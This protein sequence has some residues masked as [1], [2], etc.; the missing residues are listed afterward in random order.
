M[1][2]LRVAFSIVTRNRPAVLEHTLRQIALLHPPPDDIWVCVDGCSEGTATM[3]RERFPETHVLVE[4]LPRGSVHGRNR[5]LRESN[6][7]VVLSL[8]DDSHPIQTDFV[9][10]LRELHRLHPKVAVFAFPQVTDEFPETLQGSPLQKSECPRWIATYLDSGASYW[11]AAYLELPGFVS[12]FVHAYEEPDYALQCLG[13][14]WEVRLEP[15]LSVRHHYTAVH[16]NTLHTHLSHCRNE[17]WSILLRAPWPLVPFM[18][19]FR[20]ARQLANAGRRGGWGWLRRHPGNWWE[21]WKGA[22][23][24]LRQRHAV[25]VRTYWNWLYL[26]QR[27]QPTA[28]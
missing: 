23:A 19:I 27:P 12:Q 8:D 6:A 26:S 2:D 3:L 16:R 4:S 22:G 13:G 1:S 18:I 7:E 15:S 25:S 10:R 9:T 21:A 24:M 5:I 11:R 20:M 17:L 28:A 14:N